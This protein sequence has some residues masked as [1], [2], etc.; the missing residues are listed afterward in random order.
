MISL[1]IGPMFSG[2]T[3]E[4]IRRLNRDRI[5]GKKVIL[6]RHSI[7]KRELITHD[8]TKNIPIHNIAVEDL[9]GIDISNYDIIGIDEGQFFE[10]LPIVNLWANQKK[11]VIIAGL[12]ATSEQKPFGKI[13]DIIPICEEVI[14]L[15]AV[16]HNCGSY[17]ASFTFFKG[18]NKKN[19]VLI[20]SENE[21]E[22]RCRNCMK[23]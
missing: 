20:G 21:Y 1:I 18:K 22:A 6:I 3:T 17:N 5:A 2:K 8:H 23:I 7:D 13:L 9:S 16:C 11:N 19:D 14:K 4:L 10:D 12:D 15:N